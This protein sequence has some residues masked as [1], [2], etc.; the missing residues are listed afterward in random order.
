VRRWLETARTTPE[1]ERVLTRG[2]DWLTKT[3]TALRDQRVAEIAESPF[4]FGVIDDPTPA[5]ETSTVD[6]LARVLHEL[7]ADR[8]VV[9]FTHDS[10]RVRQ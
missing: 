2:R 3:G 4:R 5:S 1:R 9:V 6:N 10:D 8:Q 7:A